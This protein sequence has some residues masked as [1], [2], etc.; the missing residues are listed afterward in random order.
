MALEKKRGVERERSMR[1]ARA[2]AAQGR[3][4]DTK[5]AHVAPGE[6]VLPKALQTPEV[7]QDIPM[8]FKMP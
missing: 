2:L 6:I 7:R 1:Q 3:G 8:V 5:V 4:A